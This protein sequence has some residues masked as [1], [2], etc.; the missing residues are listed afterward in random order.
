[1]NN[2]LATTRRHLLGGACM[3]LPA[4]F[5][6]STFA[7]TPR[8]RNPNFVVVMT[9]DLGYGDIGPYGNRA[10]K[11]PNLDQMSAEGVTLTQYYSPAPV[12]T[13]SRAGMLT[14]RYA[15]RSGMSRVIQPWHTR[16]LPLTEVTTAKLLK[17][18]YATALFGKWHLG[19]TGAAWPPTNHGFDR[20][21]GIPYSHDMNPLQIC[22]SRAG[23]SEVKKSPVDFFYKGARLFD[24]KKDKPEFLTSSLQQRFYEAAET[25]I[26]ENRSRPFYVELWLSSP[27]LPEIPA[28]EFV[29]TTPAGRYGDMIAE[30][31][32]IMGRLRAKLRQLGIERDTLV[33][34]TSDNGP[35]FW[36]S[37]GGLRDRKGSGAYDAGSKVPF[38]AVQPG[39]I[40]AGQR[41]D[42]IAS[43]TDILPT[44]C[45]MAGKPLPSKLKLDGVDLTAVLT[46][47][48]PSRRDQIVLF[49]GQDVTAIRTQKWKYIRAGIYDLFGYDELYDL[50]N[51]PSESYNVRD[52]HPAVLEDMRARFAAAT[53]EF[54]PLKLPANDP[55]QPPTPPGPNALNAGG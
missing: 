10:I 35:W 36:G 12:C 40:P 28:K 14:G 46:A 15:I 49:T 32:S 47:G 2:Q 19:H 51:D 9:D 33:M 17:P 43:G 22:E 5:G 42:L 45:A 11:T 13:P 41:L 7:A 8:R 4:L 34:F 30:I 18:D 20:Y 44:L 38:L 53:A 3:A 21:V 25:F 39:T 52:R 55:L 48:N 1:M 37:S 24:P 26:E 16:G 50:E 54:A 29:G 27:H 23:S 6:P 31:D